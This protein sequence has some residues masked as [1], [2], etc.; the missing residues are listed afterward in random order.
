MAP[1]LFDDAYDFFAR[2]RTTIRHSFVSFLFHF[3]LTSIRQ[4]NSLATGSEQMSLVQ[5]IIPTE[6]AHD[7]VHELGEL[8]DMQFKDVRSRVNL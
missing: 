5:L 7:A 1:S 6:V 8:G 4:N 2:W 3:H